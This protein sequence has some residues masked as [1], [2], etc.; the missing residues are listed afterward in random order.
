V[1]EIADGNIAVIAGRE[2]EAATAIEIGTDTVSETGIGRET[3]TVTATVT[4]LAETP[5]TGDGRARTKVDRRKSNSF[6][7]RI[8]IGW[9]R[10]LWPIF[11]ERANAWLRNNPR[12]RSTKHWC[13]RRDELSLLLPLT[14][15]GAA[16]R[17]LRTARRPRKAR[18]RAKLS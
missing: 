8:S 10:K 6:P 7:K 12:W 2:Y 18:V 1:R 16:R 3:K 13:R 14:R 4:E 5:G 17:R 15:F 9:N 11:L